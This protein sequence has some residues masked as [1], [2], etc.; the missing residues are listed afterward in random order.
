MHNYVFVIKQEQT[1]S[2]L[3]EEISEETS[4]ELDDIF[5]FSAMYN[6][7]KHELRLNCTKNNN[8]Y[9]MSHLMDWLEECLTHPDETH[10]KNAPIEQWLI[11][12][13]PSLANLV[14]EVYPRY[15]KMYPDKNDLKSILYL[16]IMKLYDKG[17]YLHKF[18][19][20]KTFVNDLNRSIRKEKYFADKRSLDQPLS[21]DNSFTL[22]DVVPDK[23]DAIMTYE[24]RDYSEYLFNLIKTEMLTKMSELSFDMILLQIQ[25]KTI[26][27][28]T[29]K[30]LRDLRKKFS[31]NTAKRRN[32]KN[33]D[34]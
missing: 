2:D 31:P 19:I 32:R 24:E 20:R 17:Y 25:S 28:N 12:F 8:A 6:E 1:L 27:P 15:K 14:E 34:T 26:T 30:V 18:I 29:A 33:G 23:E 3:I 5:I 22:A 11:Q 9:S 13:E 16:S 4:C 7:K 10:Y 21:S